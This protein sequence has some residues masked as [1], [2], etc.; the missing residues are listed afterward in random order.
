M[1][2]SNARPASTVGSSRAIW[3]ANPSSSADSVT[4]KSAGLTGPNSPAS[5]PSTTSEVIVSRQRSSNFC[6]TPATS[7]WRAAC[8]H[9]SS[10]SSH[11]VLGASG[12]SSSSGRHDMAISSSS[13]PAAV[14]IAATRLVPVAYQVSSE[15]RIASVRSWSL[16]LK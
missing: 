2:S 4:A 9:R 8:V 15:S 16:V 5:C 14:S 10:H 1:V 13:R 7:G 11:E 3:I 12:S 6:R